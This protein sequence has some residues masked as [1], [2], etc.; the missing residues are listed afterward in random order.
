MSTCADLKLCGPEPNRLVSNSRC[1]VCMHLGRSV[2][3]R[4][5]E[6]QAAFVASHSKETLL[7]PLTSCELQTKAVHITEMD[8][9]TF[10]LFVG[11]GMMHDAW[12]SPI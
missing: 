5:V 9:L 3:D 2:S 4:C 6:A 10:F 12:R 8:N 1:K 7:T 11:C